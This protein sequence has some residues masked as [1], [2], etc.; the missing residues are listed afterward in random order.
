MLAAIAVALGAVVVRLVSLQ[1]VGPDA[2]ADAG[3]AQRLHVQQLPAERG[4]IFDRNGNELA[5]SAPQHAVW[6]DPSMVTDAATAAPL[7]ATALRLDPAKVL[8]ELAGGGRFVYLARQVSDEVAAA[9]ESLGI[10]G[11]F[12]RQEPKRFLPAG[13]LA[14]SVLGRTD[15]DGNGLSG[16]ELQ[17]DEVLRGTAGELVDER[18]PDGR[19]IAAGNRQLHPAERGD[20][21]ILTLDRSLQFHVERALEEQVTAEHALGGTAIVMDPRTGE[22]LAM[23]SVGAG[24]EGKPASPE[25]TNRALSSVYELGSVLKIVTFAAALEEG[26]ITPDLLLDVPPSLQV[27]ENLVEDSFSH[28]EMRWSTTDI[29]ALSSNVGTVKIALELGQERVDEWLRR[30][31][32]GQTTGL[33]FPTESAG[34]VLDLDEW[35]GTSI[36][37]IPLG[38]E[39]AVTALQMLTAMNA[40]ANGGERVEPTL[41]R[42]TVDAD[43]EEQP[44]SEPERE[45]VM[46]TETADALRGMLTR[47]VQTDGTGVKAAIEGYTVAGK[48]GTAQKPDP[49]RGGYEIGAYMASFAGFVPAEDP[50]LSAIVVI[51][52]P[53][54]HYYGGAVAAPTFARIAQLALHRL[55]IPPVEQSPSAPPAPTIPLAPPGTPGLPPPRD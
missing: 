43:G 35:S 23:A 29:L 8:A 53:R 9:V 36:G 45:R 48:T 21:L 3:M 18:D 51:D 4:S 55:R 52:E 31:G 13:S 2:Y 34:I 44:V 19:T 20:D 14:S 11:V 38:Q 7:I 22:I 41:V 33:G 5:M 17:Y 42:A 27:S 40:V 39:N 16:L 6:A 37:S 54:P 15:L 1:L 26:L 12:L 28:P 10:E 47:V 49:E 24:A 50:Q 46:S 25:R 30:F 32:F